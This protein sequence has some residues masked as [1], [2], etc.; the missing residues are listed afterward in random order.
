[1]GLFSAFVKGKILQKARGGSGRAAHGTGY[2]RGGRF[3]RNMMMAGAAA[4]LFKR[5]FR[6]R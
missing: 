2:S 6:R 5:L 3:G 1:M 4:M